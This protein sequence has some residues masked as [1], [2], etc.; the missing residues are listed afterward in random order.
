M[1]ID[2][3]KRKLEVIAP[4]SL[5]KYQGL[6]Y[7][8]RGV[9]GTN[10]MRLHRVDPTRTRKF[11]EVY[12]EGHPLVEAPLLGEGAAAERARKSL[13]CRLPKRVGGF[14]QRYPLTCYLGCD[15]E[16]FVE[17]ASHNLIP[18]F[19]YLPKKSKDVH[20]FWDGFQGEVTPGPQTCVELFTSHMHSLV[21]QLLKYFPEGSRM[22]ERSTVEVP[23]KTLKAAKE[24]HVRLGCEPSFNIYQDSGEPVG[25][26]REI[27]TRWAGGHLHF[28]LAGA[29]GIILLENHPGL[30]EEII[31]TL[32]LVVGVPSVL[33]AGN[34][35]DPDRRKHYGL[36]GEF[37]MPPHGLEYRTLSNFWLYHRSLAHLVGGLARASVT[38]ALDGLRGMFKVS[39]E[40][41]REVINHS[42]AKGAAEILS[43]DQENYVEAFKASFEGWSEA[44]AANTLSYILDCEK[45][46]GFAQRHSDP[47]VSNRWNLGRYWWSQWLQDHP[48]SK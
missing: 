44:T 23:Q 43:G 25:D 30:V 28:S 10:S 19:E 18:A 41:V 4:G 7:I 45:L 31:K 32:D 13:L 15:P 21:A 46:G 47:L 39:E 9:P 6:R 22:V 14:Y 38:T 2:Y 29:G 8:L 20:I 12:Q 42:D 24:E 33:L 16:L 11:S 27:G 3:V 37:R 35:D 40:R 36:A 48:Q 17:D 26:P 1:P 34:W 5:V